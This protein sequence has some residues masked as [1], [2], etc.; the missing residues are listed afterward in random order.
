[1]KS[2]VLGQN[3]LTLLVKLYSSS[4]KLLRMFGLA[5]S[6]LPCRC[7]LPTPYHRKSTPRS[8]QK[9]RLWTSATSLQR[10]SGEYIMENPCHSSSRTY[11]WKIKERETVTLHPH[12]YSLILL[13]AHTISQSNLNIFPLP[14]MGLSQYFTTYLVSSY[15]NGHNIYTHPNQQNCL[16]SMMYGYSCY[17]RRIF[18]ITD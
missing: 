10:P 1:M 13:L 8:V 18:I 9:L 3:L 11:Q 6:S 12:P 15:T 4:A 7:W 5:P 14:C 2:Y 16:L 17:F